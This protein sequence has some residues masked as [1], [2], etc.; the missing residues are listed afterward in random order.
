MVLSLLPSSGSA[1]RLLSEHLNPFTGEKIREHLTLLVFQHLVRHGHIAL[2]KESWACRITDPLEGK[3]EGF[4][5][6]KPK[7]ESRAFK[8]SDKTGCFWGYSNFLVARDT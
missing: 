8:T 1:W 7:C 4:T 6:Q 5:C 3:L 2:P